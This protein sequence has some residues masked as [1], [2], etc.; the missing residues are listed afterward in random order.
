M[1][2]V[3]L[4]IAVFLGAAMSSFAGFAFSPVAGL[5]LFAVWPPVV[6]IPLLMACSVL[7]Q[8]VS[9]IRLRNRITF[10][11]SKPMLAGGA[12]GI[13]L[14]VIILHHA[15]AARFTIAFALFLAGYALVMLLKPAAR[16]AIPDGPGVRAGVGFAGG[17]V[18]G[19]TAMPGAVPVIFCDWRGDSK[20]A[21]RAVVQPFIFAMQ[22]LALG[23]MALSGRISG[24]V[25]LL[26]SHALP[27]L[28]AGCAVGFILFGLVPHAVFRRAVLAIL[29][30]TS[31]LT[32]I[33][34]IFA[35]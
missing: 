7:V 4:F 22:I 29:L 12:A 21:Q 24:E 35:I 8:I 30:V 11:E 31:L 10:R 13:P 33:K 15:D 20:E 19:L 32:V 23:V 27:G 26:V 18:G 28:G 17:L 25:L 6:V 1:N 9:L 2:E 5:L 3:I 34:L 14:A 16:R